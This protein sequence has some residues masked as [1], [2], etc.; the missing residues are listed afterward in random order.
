M[1]YIQK[2]HFVVECHPLSAT[3]DSALPRFPTGSCFHSAG[4]TAMFENLRTH[5]PA[6]ERYR[7]ALL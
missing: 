4:D 3:Q 2:Q 1:D 5:S 6:L 7:N